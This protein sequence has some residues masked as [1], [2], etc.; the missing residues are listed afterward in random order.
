MGVVFGTVMTATG[1]LSTWG[2]LRQRSYATARTS[3]MFRRTAFVGAAVQCL[4]N[5]SFRIFF[6]AVWLYYL[7]LIV[8]T[9]LSIYFFTYYARVT[10]SAYLSLFQTLLYIMSCLGVFFWLFLSRHVQKH[11]LFFVASL[12]TATLVACAGFLVGEGNLLGT[13]NVVAIAIGQALAGLFTS[14]IWFIPSAMLADITDEDELA[15]GERREGAF[16]GLYNFA[17]QF[18]GAGA[19]LLSGVLIDW[20]AGLKPGVAVQTPLT[21]QRIGII[22][23]VLPAT[24]LAISALLIL[25][26]T[27]TRGRLVTIQQQLT[28]RQA[29]T[30][31]EG[32]RA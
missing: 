26:Y 2:T 31:D 30:D 25:R 23:S 20:F 19:L 1:L 14:V 4:R 13:G 27:L 18:A 10:E 9:S 8:N 17:Q 32:V 24:L 5:P 16:Y 7:G 22:Y 28:Q 6:L 12:A 11:R 21:V 3:R 29:V 15:T